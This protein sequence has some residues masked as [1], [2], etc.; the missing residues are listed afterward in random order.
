MIDRAGGQDAW[1]A[2]TEADKALQQ[3]IMMKQTLIL[4][5]EDK[6]AEMSEEERRDL[7]FF[8][9]T[10]CGC[11]KNL[12]SVSGGNTSMMAWWAEN[13]I[14]P[15][16]LLANRDN[17]AVLNNLDSLDDLTPAEQHAL[18]S[19][20]RGGV[21]AASLA[22]A[23][24]NYKDDK[25]GQQDTFKWWFRNAGIPIAFPDTSNN[26]YGTYCVAA[27][28]LLLYLDKF[29]EFLEFVR[30]SK[31]KRGFT[32]MEKNL[33]NALK[34]PAT[35]T[36]LAVLALYAQAISHPYMRQIRGKNQNMLD[37]AP[38]HLEVEQHMNNVIENP[39]ILLSVDA[40]Y[41]I[42]AMD[43]KEWENPNVVD[44]VLKR[45]PELPHLSDL[46][47]VFF[48]GACGT[49][50][51]FTTEFTP[52]GII[53]SATDLQ[54]ELAWMPATNDVNEGMLG[55]LRQF[56]RFNPRASLHIFNALAMYQRNDT[57]PFMNKNLQ[58]EDYKFLMR[59]GREIDS[60]GLEAKRQAKNVEYNLAKNQKKN[61]KDM[62]AAQKK[63][64]K[65]ARLSRIPLIFDKD[66]IASLKGQKLQDQLDAFRLAGAP[67]PV[68][69]KNVKTVADKKKAIHHAIDQYENDKWSPIGFEDG[70]TES[71]QADDD[72]K[73]NEEE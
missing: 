4:L 41:T 43:G 8:V 37:L 49:W 27:G 52:G 32:N 21:K 44:A 54:K 67:L 17:A 45:V 29:L 42:G 47:V 36:E 68:L 34:D 19:T 23:I 65:N 22:G 14:T 26:R 13:N 64:E 12:N 6:Y 40:T 35:L 63:V 1:E 72:E 70:E 56:W 33:Y 58:E 46:V 66:V 10:G 30:D 3:A 25:K 16:I 24:F 38:L 50:K 48:K 61:D 31:K 20:T 2:L 60:S 69:V 62:E 51:R 11:H 39:N 55:S 15:P 28:I 5:G 9:W 73:E 71:F 53:D 59:M 7:D 18:E 57:Q